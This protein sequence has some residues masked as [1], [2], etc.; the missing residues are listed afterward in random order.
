MLASLRGSYEVDSGR[1]WKKCTGGWKLLPPVDS[2]VAWGH[3]WEQEQARR[4]KHPLPLAECSPESCST[5]GQGALKL[6]V[7]SQLTQSR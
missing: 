4:N 7:R 3:G 6:G 1:V 5:A 2:T